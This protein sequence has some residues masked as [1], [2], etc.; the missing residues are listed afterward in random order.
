[1][2]GDVIIQL[3]NWHFVDLL[4][5]PSAHGIYYGRRRIRLTRTSVRCAVLMGEEPFPIIAT[6]R[7][8]IV[9]RITCAVTRGAV[10]DFQI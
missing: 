7:F 3:G 2:A 4:A 1:L 6:G 8:D 5:G 9:I 10:A